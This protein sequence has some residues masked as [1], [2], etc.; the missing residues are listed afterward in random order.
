MLSPLRSIQ[1]APRSW[2]RLRH[3]LFP[4]EASKHTNSTYIPVVEVTLGHVDTPR[5]APTKFTDW[6]LVIRHRGK[7]TVFDLSPS[8]DP[9]TVFHLAAF[10]SD[11]EHEIFPITSGY[12]LTLTY[13]LY[14]V[15]EFM[16]HTSNFYIDLRNSCI[17]PTSCT[18]LADWHQ[19]TFLSFER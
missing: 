8:A 4:I 1:E 16:P 3:S 10:V 6:T 17:S 13:N 2:V 9:P 7:E 12:C 18:M 11:V 14:F 19:A 5:S 15:K